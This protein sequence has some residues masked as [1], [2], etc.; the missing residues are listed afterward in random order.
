[1]P[2]RT[3]PSQKTKRASV[4]KQSST[5]IARTELDIHPSQKALA[6][7][8]VAATNGAKTGL[9]IVAPP[10]F[11]KTRAVSN[12]LDKMDQAGDD[13]AFDLVVFVARTPALARSQAGEVGS[14]Y[15]APMTMAHLNGLAKAITNKPP[16]ESIRVT[17]TQT[18]FKSLFS[19]YNF[20]DNFAKP[21]GSP[22]IHIVL[23]EAHT[24]YV[25]SKAVSTA[26]AAILKYACSMR[27]TGLTA[28]PQLEG[29]M[30]KATNLF[31]GAPQIV[32]YT[33]QEIARFKND[34]LSHRPTSDPKWKKVELKPPTVDANYMD[35][36]RTI[37]VGNVMS[38]G[39]VHINAWNARNTL[40]SLVQ[41]TQVHGDDS[42][43]GE[44]FKKLASNDVTWKLAGEGASFSNKTRPQTALIVHRYPGGSELHF[45][46]LN[47]L[48]GEEGVT[49]FSI[50]DL[51]A[52]DLAAFKDKLDSF[53]EDVTMTDKMVLAVVDKH[54]IEGT[55]NYAK[56]VSTIVAVGEWT[57]AELTQLG[58]RLGRPCE[59]EPGDLL[60]QDVKLIHF[61]SKWASKVSSVGLVRHSP[62][63][64]KEKV[65]TELSA[66]FE[67]L[68]DED[69]K[70]WLQLIDGGTVLG[71]DL[72]TTYMDAME[73]GSGFMTTYTEQVKKWVA[74]TGQDEA[75]DDGEE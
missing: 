54:Q 45:S 23:D 68:D 32:E 65:P 60:P 38:Q 24:F 33:P 34:L 6:D 48:V 67:A 50:H 71:S 66:K 57:E 49:P 19:N 18:M 21:L 40:T 7:R 73:E 41:A 59:Y 26:M 13:N 56:N 37:V 30:Q 63:T 16:N 62:R 20:V 8:F 17:M 44:L 27:V 35:P 46:M 42:T 1:M 64:N 43:G 25:K 31:G 14:Q 74:F 29:H 69:Q 52:T 53:T 28:T 12:A 11:G 39:S 47:G 55:N 75:S 70:K 72:L 4:P 3:K 51:R 5:K 61:H 15:K 2:S 10:G 9:M 36:L 58:G 22:R